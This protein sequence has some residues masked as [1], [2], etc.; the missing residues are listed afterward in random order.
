MIKRSQL[1]DQIRILEDE[2]NEKDGKLVQLNRD[3]DEADK[4]LEDKQKM[5]EQI[6]EALKEVDFCSIGSVETLT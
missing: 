4:A 6:V 3:L 1:G 5:H 2:L